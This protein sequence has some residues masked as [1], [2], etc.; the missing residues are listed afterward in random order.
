MIAKGLCWHSRLWPVV[1]QVPGRSR[2]SSVL[3]L[4][5]DARISTVPFQSAFLASFGHFQPHPATLNSSPVP[6]ARAVSPPG[7]CTDS[8]RREQCSP[9]RRA[10]DSPGNLAEKQILTVGPGGA[11]TLHVLLALL[12][13]CRPHFEQRGPRMPSP[14]SPS[15][16]APRPSEPGSDHPS[17]RSPHRSRI[18]KA[19][20]A[21]LD[22]SL[23]VTAQCYSHK[24]F[25]SPCPHQE[26]EA[27]AVPCC[28]AQDWHRARVS[29]RPLTE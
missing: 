8:P 2:H 19:P 12:L 18:R 13:V 29:E 21:L 23:R 6:N 25:P 16:A 11:E 1:W 14:Y 3:V 26:P 9:A 17:A 22:T 20:A 27:G 4:T 5:G 7:L 24:Q 28:P 15:K 10:R